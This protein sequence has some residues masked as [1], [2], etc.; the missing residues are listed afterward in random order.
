MKK[1]ILIY[2]LSA[3]LC[4]SCSNYLDI[5][6]YGKTIPKTAEEFS[7]LLHSHLQNIDTGSD[8][9]LVGNTSQLLVW[10]AGCGDDFETCL[11]AS[12]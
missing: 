3:F 9:L 6:P 12:G 7:A 8:K 5:K 1:N 10:D 11:T 2:G 4:M